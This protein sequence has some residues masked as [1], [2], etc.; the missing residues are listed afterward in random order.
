L[1]IDDF[2]A[3]VR[4]IASKLE[5]R[6]T[7]V[8]RDVNNLWINA[9]SNISETRFSTTQQL[10]SVDV[11]TVM[12]PNPAVDMINERIAAA[13]DGMIPA[14]LSTD[15]LEADSMLVFTNALYLHGQWVTK[16]DPKSTQVEQFTRFDGSAI[17][18]QIMHNYVE[19]PYV[20]NDLVQ[21]VF[22]PYT[23]SSCE[24]VAILP[25][26]RT[27]ADFRH[28]LTA[29]DPSWLNS[30][31]D[32]RVHLRLPKFRVQGPTLSLNA[33]AKELG[34]KEVFE[35]GARIFPQPEEEQRLEMGDI[36]QQVVIEV[37]EAGTRAAVFTL[38]VLMRGEP[39]EEVWVDLDRPFAYLI[40]NRATR[41]ILLMGTY[42]DPTGVA[43]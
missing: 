33:L 37:D 12:F 35:A 2:A 14:A 41:T 3:A 29:F 6:N 25:R 5:S 23:D 20:A 8:L 1:P 15:S 40:R 10:L 21:L 19:V 28:A 18:T 22:L 24:F 17:E 30:L 36:K 43:H 31:E 9:A 34:L 13:T 7:F 26:N 16:F 32:A 39:P 4:D 42:L 38:S 11:S 27:E